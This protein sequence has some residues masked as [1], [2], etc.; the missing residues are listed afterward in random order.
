MFSRNDPLR[1]SG[2]DDYAFY[3]RRF[4]ALSFGAWPVSAQCRWPGKC[5]A[6]SLPRPAGV[7]CFEGVVRH[8]IGHH[9]CSD[10]VVRE[11][12]WVSKLAVMLRLNQL[13]FLREAPHPQLSA[14]SD[15]VSFRQ[16][17]GDLVEQIDVSGSRNTIRYATGPMREF[18]A[19]TIAWRIHPEYGRNLTAPRMP[20]VLENWVHR[21]FPFLDDEL[22][23][24][25]PAYGLFE[26]RTQ[27]LV[28]QSLPNETWV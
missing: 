14:S 18:A 3:D 22:D 17:L 26:A 28:S 25:P 2:R 9:L 12:F 27:A 6:E 20:A 23:Q 15:S 21:C 19:E 13:D 8:Q 7:T 4:G 24:L 11:S 5:L 10:N 16:T 1:G